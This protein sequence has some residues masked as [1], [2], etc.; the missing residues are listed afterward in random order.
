MLFVEEFDPLSPAAS[1]I[2][3]LHFRPDQRNLASF[4]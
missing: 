3:Q 2:M 1:V 4:I